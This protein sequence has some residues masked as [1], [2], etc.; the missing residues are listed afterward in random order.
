MIRCLSL[1]QPWASAVMVGPKDVENR[2]KPIFAVPSGGMWIGI[3]AST[4]RR[5][6]GMDPD[7]QIATEYESIA[8]DWPEGPGDR[9]FPMGCVLGVVRVER[10]VDFNPNLP[11]VALIREA[12]DQLGVWANGP[13]CYVLGE[14]RPLDTPIICKGALGLW[15]PPPTV[16]D[17]L[18]RLVRR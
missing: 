16:G 4:T 6:Y 9:G 13:V 18:E 7:K 17:A 8:E 1:T 2:S 3:H 15:P 5:L 10:R 11:D 14:K 12:H